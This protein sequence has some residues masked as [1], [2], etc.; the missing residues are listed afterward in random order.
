VED[1]RL[2]LSIVLADLSKETTQ[3]Q[4][5]ERLIRKRRSA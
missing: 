3:R 5:A 4:G 2:A 1:E